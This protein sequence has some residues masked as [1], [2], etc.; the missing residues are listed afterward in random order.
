MIRIP[1]RLTV[2][3][4][5]WH[6]YLIVL[7][8]SQLW[9]GFG[10]TQR[11]RLRGHET[12]VARQT[13]DGPTGGRPVRIAYDE[14]GSGP[15]VIYLHGSPGSGGDARRLAALLENRFRLIAPDLPGFGGSTRWL[16]DYGIEAHARY[17]LALMDRLGIERTHFISHS[18]GSGVALHITRLAPERVATITSYAGIGIQEG[19][20][21]GD[22]HLEHFKYAVGYGLLVAAPELV[23]HFGLLG[24]RSARHAFIRN[25]WDTD[26]RPLRALLEKLEVPLLI[27]HGRDDPLVRAWVAEEHHRIVGHSELVMLDA[28][29]FLVFTRLGSE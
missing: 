20:G 27:L 28:S 1:R 7:V 17:V 13:A 29:Q 26:Q 15:P 25:F 6:V 18:M 8:L 9:Q 3:L 12:E 19:E 10:P 21:S 22:Y 2:R 16:P 4:R 24:S 23:P 14:F 5:W 11:P